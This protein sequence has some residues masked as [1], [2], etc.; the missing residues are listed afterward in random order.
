MKIGE[1]EPTASGSFAN[2]TGAIAGTGIS[3]LVN[4]Q[5]TY[6][7]VGV[8]VEITPHVHENGD[9]SLHVSL[10]ISSVTGAGESG[11]NQRAHHRPAQDRSGIRLHEGEVN[12]IGGLLSTQDNKTK[13]GVPGWPTFLSWASC[14]AATAWTASAMK[15]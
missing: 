15:S 6:L 11:R 12:L 5:F 14:S 7:D 2:T 9:V 4:T 13:T 10:D 3:P 8:N 1:K